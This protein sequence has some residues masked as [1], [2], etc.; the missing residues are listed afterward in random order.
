MWLSLSVVTAGPRGTRCTLD[1]CVYINQGLGDVFFY[2]DSLYAIPVDCTVPIGLS[3]DRQ[4]RRPRNRQTDRE[5]EREKE[6]EIEREIE[7]E[8]E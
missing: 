3:L 7:R 8:Q 4:T 5:A 1:W 2:G 6:R